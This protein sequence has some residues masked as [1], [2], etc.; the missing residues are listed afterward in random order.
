MWGRGYAPEAASAVIRWAFSST[1]TAAL[2]T[3]SEDLIL[4]A[5]HHPHN[6]ASQRVLEK[7]G[8]LFVRT[9]LYAPTGLQHPSYELRYV[10]FVKRYV[11]GSTAPA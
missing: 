7:L 1:G 9:E 2:K 10:D 5:G 4:F 6:A 8:F 11:E 3:T